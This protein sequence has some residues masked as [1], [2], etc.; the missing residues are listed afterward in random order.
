MAKDYYEILGVSRDADAKEIK[1]AYRKLAMKYHPDQNKDNPDAEAKFKEI[2]V[3][4]DVL[5]DPEKR[6]KY[7]RMG[8]EN[9]ERGYEASGGYNDFNS[10]NFEDFA[11]IF[12][13]IFGGGGSSQKGGGGFSFFENLFGGGGRRQ[14]ANFRSGGFNFNQGQGGFQAQKGQNVKTNLKIP[15]SDAVKG[16]EKTIVLNGNKKI[17]V[18]IPQGVKDGQ[19]IKLKG[20]GYPSQTGGENGDLIIELSIYNDTDYERDGNN[21]KKNIPL[22]LKTALQGGKID[23]NTFWGTISLKIPPKTSGGKVFKIPGFGVRT[24][25]SKGDLFLRVE[26]KLPDNLNDEKIKEIVKILDKK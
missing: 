17:N 7:D 23:V 12:G 26:I 8:H 13:D 24:K 5:S 15:F 1:K 4:Y 14:S 10:A 11:D 3:A 20:Q 19:K 2:S 18:K 21:L 25:N 16:N 22:D 6:K 9:F